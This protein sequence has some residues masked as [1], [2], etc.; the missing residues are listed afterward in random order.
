LKS[1]ITKLSV[2]WVFLCQWVFAASINAQELQ[3]SETTPSFED[4]IQLEP[5]SDS[6]QFSAVESVELLLEQIETVEAEQ[7]SFAPELGELSFE[8]GLQ[9]E[10]LG[11]HEDALEAF[12]RADQ[13]MKIREG[14]YSNNRE[15]LIRKIFDQ[16]VAL[17]DWESAEIALDNNAWLRARN[18]DSDSLDYVEVL[19][20]LVRWNLAVDHYDIEDEES[21]AL[22]R[23]YSDL[24]E[25]FDIYAA[26][27]MPADDVTI[28]LAMTVNHMLSQQVYIVDSVG[29]RDTSAALER[30][31]FRQSRAAVMACHSL[32]NEAEEIR[33]RCSRSAEREIRRNLPETILIDYSSGQYDQN[34][35]FYSRSYFRGKDLLL[36]QLEILKDQGDQRRSLDTIMKLGDWY[37]LFGYQRS[38]EEMYAAAWAYANQ[39][40]QPEVIHM[41]EPMAISSAGLVE[42]LPRLV[43]GNRQGEAQVAVTIARTGEIEKIEYLDTDIDDESVI[44]D[45]SANLAGSIYR[46]I[47]RDGVPI[48]AVAYTVNKQVSY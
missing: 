30:K 17:N 46:P 25:I 38:A 32:Y 42:S 7:N 23:A 39:I 4:E 16:H 15:I 1:S 48:A 5:D 13:N 21:V 10:T 12:L 20:E 43:V 18:V 6:L 34:I 41:Q 45:L 9:L 14:L 8:L 2:F 40:G 44:A 35:S 24:E 3:I 36:D 27:D 31:Y 19:Q 37:L 47:L 33:D 11:L 22:I 28:D 26:R 29:Q